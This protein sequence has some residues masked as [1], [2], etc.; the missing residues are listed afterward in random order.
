MSKLNIFIAS[1]NHEKFILETL[2]SIKL[3]NID[4]S[5]YIID[6]GSTD[7][8]VSIINNFISSNNLSSIF[9]IISKNNAGLNDTLQIA[10][11]LLSTEYCYFTASDD[12]SIAEGIEELVEILESNKSIDFAIGGAKNL[13]EDGSVSDV[14]GKK[15]FD[16]FNDKIENLIKNT[17]Y[18]CPQPIL[19]QSTVF[20]TS[21]I[22]A[23]NGWDKDI[24]SD[25]F[26]MWVK[27]FTYHFKIK[28]SIS[29]FFPEI[30]TAFYRHH[31]N[32]SY[33]KFFRQYKF[34]EQ[35][36]LKYAP[37]EYIENA[38]AIARVNYLFSALKYRKFQDFV[39]LIKGINFMNF[40]LIFKHSI[41]FIF[42]RI[43]Y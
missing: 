24:S 8:S 15:H 38:L 11:N 26:A 17:F 16:F 39:S 33:K 4:K 14:Y 18:E 20:R 30:N 35:V 40:S 27:I 12:I 7:N 36:V 9:K 23:V 6:D 29:N 3:I 13:Y 2:E 37:D 42:K 22:K 28:K 21:L 43:F 10:Y 25:D 32:N 31:G 5:V 1:Y 19:F 34:M 41:L